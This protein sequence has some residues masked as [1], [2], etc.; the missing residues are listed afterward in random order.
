MEFSL[1]LV[2]LLVVLLVANCTMVSGKKMCP[3]AEGPSCFQEAIS[4]QESCLMVCLM[5]REIVAMLMEVS[6]MALGRQGEG[7]AWD[8]SLAGLWMNTK[9]NG[10]EINAQGKVFGDQA[11]EI[12]MKGFG[13]QIFLMAKAS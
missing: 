8:P 3:V 12:H 4:T 10:L 7:M 2:G 13:I 11:E 1:A 5:V 9:A 6:I